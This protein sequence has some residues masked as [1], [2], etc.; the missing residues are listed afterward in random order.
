M[1]TDQTDL[2]TVHRLYPEFRTR[3]GLQV[4]R[5][6]EDPTPSRLKKTVPGSSFIKTEEHGISETIFVSRDSESYFCRYE[7]LCFRV[8]TPAQGY[9]E[10]NSF[11]PYPT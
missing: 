3:L 7:V 4:R 6:K 2:T 9:F 11:V 8:P 1:F 10:I 5:K